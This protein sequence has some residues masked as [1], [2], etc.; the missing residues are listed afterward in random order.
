MGQEESVMVD[1]SAAPSTLSARS[2]AAVA[3]YVN[4]GPKKRIVVLTGAGIST[5]AGIPDFRSPN[6]GLYHNLARLNLP[7]AEAVFD[8]DYFRKHPEPFYVLAHELYPGRFHPTVSHAFI[9]LLARRGLLQML[10]TQNIDCLE[11]AAGLPPELIVEAHGSFATQRCIDCRQVISD[12]AM[13]QHVLGRRVPRCPSSSCGGIVK[14]DIVFF[15]ESLPAAFS[16]QAHSVG[17][18]D[19]LLILGTSLSVFPFAGLA[20]MAPASTP[21]LLLNHERVGRIGSQADDVIELGPCDAG[22]RKFADALGWRDELEDMWR[23]IVGD[24]EAQRQLRNQNEVDAGL[25]DE[26]QKLTAGVEAA[27]RLGS[28]EASSDEDVAQQ[29]FSATDA[30]TSPTAPA[31]ASTRSD[32]SQEHKR[33]ER[34]TSHEAT[35]PA[36]AVENEPENEPVHQ[37]EKDKAH[38]DEEKMDAQKAS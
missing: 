27:L 32:K 9:A 3:D 24:D 33:A 18:A 5:A 7:Y 13:R 1:E 17:N 31:A 26:V 4:G 6:T 25:E 21:R 38:T 2:L 28:D 35:A 37:T 12:E 30:T 36:D 14:P 22:V 16:Q 29:R 15:G 20:N 34:A 23:S 10:F 8:I 11:R 19:L